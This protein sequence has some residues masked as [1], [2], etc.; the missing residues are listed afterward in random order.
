MGNVWQYAQEDYL[1]GQVSWYIG[2]TSRVVGDTLMPN[3]RTYAVI[4]S[5]GMRAGSSWMRQ[6]GSRIVSYRTIELD[7]EYV[8]Y[9]F[10]K[11]T[12]DTMWVTPVP[13]INDTMFEIIR[14]VGP[15]TTFNVT[16]GAQDYSTEFKHRT[17]YQ[18]ER[19]VDGFGLTFVESEG[20]D[21]WL[22]RGAVIGGI[23][24]G[25]ITSVHDA[26]AEPPSEYSLQQ[27]YPNPFN[28]TTLI[29]FSLLRQQHVSLTIYN[30]LGMEVRTLVDDVL[31]KGIHVVRWDGKDTR[32]Y[33]LSSGVYIYRVLV[34]QSSISK[35]MKLVK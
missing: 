16:K 24:Y 14:F 6:V 19:I 8:N 5:D 34:G 27:N 10:S 29:E 2:W 26:A 33:S 1:N 11:T 13:Q 23:Q 22:L 9:D 18:L 21:T 32:G 35:C 25:T 3:G 12:G 28:G 17:T 15:A 31:S 30:I 7:S 4:S 20:G